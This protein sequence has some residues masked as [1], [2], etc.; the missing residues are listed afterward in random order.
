MSNLPLDNAVCPDLD[1][2]SGRSSD[3][4]AQQ[5][6]CTRHNPSSE[7]TRRIGRFD[8]RVIALEPFGLEILGPS[9]ADV[10][11][12]YLHARLLG[13]DQRRFFFQLV[14]DEGV[15]VCAN[16]RGH[17]PTYRNV[18]G[19]SSRG[20][21]SQAE[22][23]H[24]DGCSAPENPRIVE[25]CCPQGPL[26]RT[27]PTAVARFPV[28]V[29]AMLEQIPDSWCSGEGGRE[30]ARARACLRSDG[31]IAVGQSD[32]HAQWH[33]IQG[34]ALRTIRREL[35]SEGARALLRDVDAAAGAFVRPWQ[36]GE[37]RFIANA[38]ARATCQHRR[39]HQ[40]P[41]VQGAPRGSLVKR[42]PAE[43][44]V[45]WEMGEQAGASTG[46]CARGSDEE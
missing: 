24:H 35:D 21:L 38:N 13:P 5:P 12:D 3:I 23:Y 44:L 32:Q 26:V 4:S 25:I 31:G 1:S 43:E 2:V 40:Q 15:V 39:A 42:W 33:T 18:R 17:H 9:I 28:T 10:G 16:G 37:S 19:R 22:Y 34:L 8:F 7:H 14:D 27:V 46:S 30:L 41:L 36:P 6:R 29:H 20:R 11:D 45:V